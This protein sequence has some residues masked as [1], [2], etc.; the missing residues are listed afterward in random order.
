VIADGD[1]LSVVT[2]S[3]STGL[4]AIP[5]MVDG[6]YPLEMILNTGYPVSLLSPT[7]RDVLLSLGHIEYLGGRFYRLGNFTIGG[8]PAPAVDVRV[9]ASIARLGIEGA[10]GLN[11]LSL[12][13]EVH[14]DV[15]SWQLTLTF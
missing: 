12:F 6:F 3:H 11:F 5:V 10:L 8:R 2:Y 1:E 7:T 4:I 15:R 14:F 9:N 13:T